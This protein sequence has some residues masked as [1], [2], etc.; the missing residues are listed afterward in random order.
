[1]SF[2]VNLLMLMT[3]L[4]LIYKFLS[5]TQFYRKSPLLRLIVGVIFYIPCLVYAI[6]EKIYDTLPKIPGISGFFK[7]TGATGATGAT[8]TKA[9][10][11]A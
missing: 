2:I 6:V 3:M 8:A 11:T 4:G 7:K 9:A 1:M 5:I 10:A